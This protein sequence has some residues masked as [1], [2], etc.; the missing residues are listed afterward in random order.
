MFPVASTSLEQARDVTA[1]KTALVGS[2]FLLHIDPT[3]EGNVV[4]DL[5]GRFLG[6][7]VVPPGVRIL[8]ATDRNA[9]VVGRAFPWADGRRLAGFEVLPIDGF[10]REIVIPLDNDCAFAFGDDLTLPDC[11]YFV[12]FSG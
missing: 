6:I 9:V 7:W 4:L 2:A 10:R 1:S 11:S 3:P 5:S 8:L 12:S